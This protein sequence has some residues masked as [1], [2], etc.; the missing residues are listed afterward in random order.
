MN[1]EQSFWLNP[2]VDLEKILNSSKE[3]LTEKEAKVRFKQVG[4]NLISEHQKRNLLFQFLSRFRSPL[5]IL[6]VLASIF[7]FFVGQIQDASIILTIVMFS[8]LIDFFQEYRAGKAA[9]KLRKSVALKSIVLRDG[10]KSEIFSSEIVPGD[11]VFLSAGNLVPADGRLLFANDVFAN[12]AL[13]TGESFPVEKTCNDLTEKEDDLTHATNALFM[14]SSL[15]SGQAQMLVCETASRTFLG[16]IADVLEKPSPPS[17]FEI[18]TR[19]F[20]YLLMRI[21]IFLTLFVLIVNL[22]FHRPF[23]ETVLFA[24]ALAV[25]MTPE[26]LPMVVSI[27]L[28]RGSLRMSHKKV[29]VKR[30]S[31]IH[32]LGSMD[33][34]CTDKTGTLTEAHIELA[35][36]LDGNGEESENVLQLSYLNSYFES[37]IKSTLDQAVL[38]KKTVSTEGWEK[39]DEIPFDFERRKISVLLDNGTERLL[40]V[41]GAPEDILHSCTHFE[42]KTVEDLL[43]LDGQ[44][45]QHYEALFED[46]SRQGFR[47]LGVAYRVMPKDYSHAVISDESGLTFAGFATFFDP[48]KKSSIGALELLTK[49]NVDL[50]IV[51]GDNEFVTSHL[52]NL[53]RIPIQGILNGSEI[54]KMSHEALLGSVKKTNL[55]CRV[56]PSQKTRIITALKESGHIVGYMGDGI[57]DAPSLHTAHVGISVDSAVDVAKEAADFILLKRDLKVIN[58]GVVE[59]RRTFGNIMKYVMMV[60][61]SNL[62]NIIS[63]AA[64]SLFIPFLPMLAPQILL[65]NLLY[66]VSETPIPLDNVDKEVLKRPR[67]W[68]MSLITKFM[69]ILGPISSFFDFLIFY[70]M[71]IGLRAGEAF[72]QTGWFIESLATQILVIFVIRTRLSPFK[73]RPSPILIASSLG[74]LGIA[75]M[76]IY[77]PLGAYFSFVKLPLYFYAIL[78][79]MV[80]AYLIIAETGKRYFYRRFG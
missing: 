5:V 29:I 34:L 19:Q 75:I 71:L 69:L 72:F 59:G 14:G 4:P 25:G 78:V 31:A 57:N 58:D 44:A 35:K 36:H 18:G 74:M 64:A 24:L 52:C 42:G 38:S 13:L 68:S 26:F 47:V 21:T 46:Q 40:I 48:P 66:D 8:V 33:V 76:I 16:G 41:K 30:L 39:I 63:M 56:T 65:N 61:S 77:S 12:Q 54:S 67:Q 9:E 32:D 73:S 60:T 27:T 3:G 79:P 15:I 53:L 2:L 70:I 1:D 20:G 80:C 11:I 43:P 50:K 22:F 62:G 37:G 55:F 51:S 23:L 45:L 49:N 28:A 17:A 10:Q 6:L 7:S